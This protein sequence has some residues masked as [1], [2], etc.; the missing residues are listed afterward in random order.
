[1]QDLAVV[2]VPKAALLRR[3]LLEQ[4]LGDDVFHAGQVRFGGVAVEQRALRE[5]LVDLVAEVVRLH[6]VLRVVLHRVEADQV[7]VELRHRAVVLQRLG[8]G[9]EHVGPRGLV[10]TG[11]MDGGIDGLA[12]GTGGKREQGSG[13]GAGVSCPCRQPRAPRVD[14]GSRSDIMRGPGRSTGRGGW[15]WKWVWKSSLR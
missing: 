13:G 15:P 12:A 2:R 8:A 10:G 4:P 11:W 6:L 5:V 7:D 14:A 3:Q 9:F 1:G